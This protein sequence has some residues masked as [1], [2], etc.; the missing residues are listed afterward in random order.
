[1]MTQTAPKPHF[2]STMA[3]H[4]EMCSQLARAFGNHR[5]ERLDPFEE[6]VY[7]VKNHDRCWVNYDAIQRSIRRRGCRTSW[8]GRHLRTL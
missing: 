1:M 2:V 4:T 6:V 3:E 8:H 7:V 5:F